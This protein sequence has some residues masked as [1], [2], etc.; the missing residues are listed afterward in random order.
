M[1]LYFA[2]KSYSL[3]APGKALCAVENELNCS[4]ISIAKKLLEGDL[5]V[6]D[7]A[8][9][10]FHFIYQ[11]DPQNALSM[12]QIA[13]VIVSEGIA[14]AIENLSELLADLLGKTD[15]TENYRN[16]LETMQRRFPDII[17]ESARL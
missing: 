11:S 17:A 5:L 14:Q 6:D 15:S 7:M 1:H 3:S 8:V 9:V 10:F 16:E 2:D 12:E 13:E 4:I